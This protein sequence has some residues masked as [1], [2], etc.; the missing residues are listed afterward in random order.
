MGD[1]NEAWGN[2]N[3]LTVMVVYAGIVPSTTREP[4]VSS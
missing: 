4:S 1:K 2:D 3:H